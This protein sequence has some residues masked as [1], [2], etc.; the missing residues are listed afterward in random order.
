MVYLDHLAQLG[1]QDLQVPQDHRD[2]KVTLCYGSTDQRDAI[3]RVLLAPGSAE[4]L[5]S[6]QL[7]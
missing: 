7:P 1:I 2:L 5:P 4:T 3:S 6:T